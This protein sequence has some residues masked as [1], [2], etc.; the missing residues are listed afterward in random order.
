LI[1]F[2]FDLH[3]NNFRE[4]LSGIIEVL[5]AYRGVVGA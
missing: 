2:G 5:D 4:K 3:T 1:H